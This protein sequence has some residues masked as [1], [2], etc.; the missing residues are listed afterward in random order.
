MVEIIGL[1]TM[2]M[3]VW[4]IAWAMSGEIESEKRRISMYRENGQSAASA[5]GKVRTRLAA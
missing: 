5:A 2:G 3:L 1:V 4:L